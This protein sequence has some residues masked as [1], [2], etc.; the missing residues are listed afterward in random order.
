[1]DAAAEDVA[2]GLGVA[3]LFL[4]VVLIW[5]QG[6]GGRRLGRIVGG[7]AIF[8]SFSSMV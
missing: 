5:M 8:L 1:V 7:Y 2:V 3:H 6:R 4:S